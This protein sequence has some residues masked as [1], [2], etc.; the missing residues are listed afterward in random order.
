MAMGRQTDR[1]GDLM[2]TW[3]EMPRSPGHVF[4]DR[5]QQVLLD[6]GFDSFVETTCKPFYAATMGARS[7]PPGRYFRMHMVGY[8]EGIDSERGIEWRAVFGLALLA[9]VPAAG[10][11]GWRTASGCPTI[12][13][14]QRRADACR[15]RSMRRYSAGCWH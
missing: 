1:Q 4:Y 8:F 5:L 3:S 15:K 11:C 10:S 7:V 9:R 14:C 6:A 2:M 13:G 12:P